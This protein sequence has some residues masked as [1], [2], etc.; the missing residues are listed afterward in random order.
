M[1]KWVGPFYLNRLSGPPWPQ[2]TLRREAFLNISCTAFW[3][4]DLWNFR[5]QL[6]GSESPTSTVP[7]SG[8]TLAP[9]RFARGARQ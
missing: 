5:V 2:S 3:E 7:A 8:R 9:S 4:L 6:H 1:T